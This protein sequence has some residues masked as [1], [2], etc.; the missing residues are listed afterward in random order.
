MKKAQKVTSQ[1]SQKVTSQTTP[2]RRNESGPK[3]YLANGPKRLH[4]KRPP[5]GETT[6]NGGLHVPV[7]AASCSMFHCFQAI[8]L[9]AS[10]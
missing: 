8:I 6:Q 5:G 2:R 4:R 7:M 3:G 10:L 1:T 9:V